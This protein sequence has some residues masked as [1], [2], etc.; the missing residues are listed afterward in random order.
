M[1]GFYEP[2]PRLLLVS[3]ASGE[4]MGVHKRGPDGG[5]RT[6][7]F[8]EGGAGLGGVVRSLFRGFGLLLL[9]VVVRTVTPALVFGQGGCSFGHELTRYSKASERSMTWRRY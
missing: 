1:G 7:G 8:R 4:P 6:S 5:L 3:A 9:E 2:W